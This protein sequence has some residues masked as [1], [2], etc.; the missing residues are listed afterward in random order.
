MG[1][2]IILEK[3]PPKNSMAKKRFFKTGFLDQR[4]E[5]GWSFF[6]FPFSFSLER[7]FDFA[8]E[9]KTLLKKACM[10]TLLMMGD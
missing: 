4:G 2:I 3:E 9:R 8:S 6:S 5:L 1:G 10:Y 7:R